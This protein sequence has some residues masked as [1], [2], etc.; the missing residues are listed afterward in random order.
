[1]INR[2]ILIKQL[3]NVGLSQNTRIPF[4]FCEGLFLA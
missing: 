2:L 4:S 3:W 1:M